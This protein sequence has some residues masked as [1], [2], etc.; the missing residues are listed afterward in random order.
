VG[1]WT[2]CTAASGSS[3]SSAS[4]PA[5][6]RDHGRMLPVH[7]REPIGVIHRAH[8]G[9]QDA[10]EERRQLAVDVGEFTRELVEVLTAAGWSE[11]QARNVLKLAE[12]EDE[13]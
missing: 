8:L 1:Q 4:E 5:L 10:V 13:R 9:Y 7:R 3:A 2:C 12:A 11:E 6:G